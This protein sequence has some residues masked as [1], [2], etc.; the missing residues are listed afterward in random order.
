MAMSP[1]EQIAQDMLDVVIFGGLT[2]TH[3]G[4]KTKEVNSKGKSFWCITF[5][6]KN[7]IEGQIHVYSE[8]FIIVKW[9]ANQGQRGNKVFKYDGDCK[10]FIQLIVTFITIGATN[11]LHPLLSRIST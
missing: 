1:R 10:K 2:D 8:K 9:T 6:K 7:I 11:D 3:H 4:I 5:C